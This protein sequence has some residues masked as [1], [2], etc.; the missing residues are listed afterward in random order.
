VRYTQETV[1]TVGFGA[2]HSV[3]PLNRY[4]VAIT[5]GSGNVTTSALASTR[6][7]IGQGHGI[8]FAGTNGRDVVI[9]DPVL[10]PVAQ[11]E[12]FAKSTNNLF[13]VDVTVL[14]TFDTEAITG[15]GA[16]HDALYAV[17]TQF[18]VGAG[19]SKQVAAENT[20]RVGIIFASGTLSGTLLVTTINP[21]PAGHGIPVGGAS[22]VVLIMT[23]E[24][25]LPAIQK[26]WFAIYSAAVQYDITIIEVFKPQIST[27]I[28][29]EATDAKN[30]YRQSAGVDRR[31][32][33]GPTGV[34]SQPGSLAIPYTTDQS[35]FNKFWADRSARPGPDNP[36]WNPGFETDQGGNW[37]LDNP[38][39]A[40]Y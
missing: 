23:D 25:T 14:E 37:G 26:S 20:Q 12:W 27:T 4:R 10:L 24:A 17:E 5:L 3:A 31:N 9:D 39:R 15:Q 2:P 21:P 28:A 22:N 35:V 6:G 11:M 32:G 36:S 38:R 1:T 13:S 18:T 7:D 8:G 33:H 16:V 29:T 19:L 34:G 40:G 30:G